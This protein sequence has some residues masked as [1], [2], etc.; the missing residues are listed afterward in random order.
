MKKSI[1]E[2][3]REIESIYKSSAQAVAD[4]YEALVKLR[5]E[6][7]AVL[8]SKELTRQGIEKK[9]N[10]INEKIK[11][12]EA[13]MYALRKDAN[14]R[15]MVIRQ[16]V[17]K[18]FYNYFHANAG[19]V[20]MQMMTLINSGVLSDNELMH[21][22]ENANTTMKRL[23]GRALENSK[24]GLYVAEGRKMQEVSN[25]AHLRAVDG[26]IGI[27]DYA[28][29]GGRLSGA[30]GAKTYLAKWNEM[31]E[32]I[33]DSAPNVTYNSDALKPGESWFTEE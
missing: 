30:S 26:L 10:E 25:N 21:M 2:Y 13:D 1:K 12:I 19:D 6:R 15:A 22:A 14:A 5:G 27:G 24:E 16:N 8:G 9:V 11:V 28:C 4:D 7:A 33:I 20:D 23:I 31:I 18:T 29:G 3:L 17:D 32:P